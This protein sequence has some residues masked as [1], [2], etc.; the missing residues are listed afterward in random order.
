[1]SA[2]PSGLHKDERRVQIGVRLLPEVVVR[3]DAQ[4]DRL[5]ISRNH[6]IAMLVDYGID[7]L[8]AHPGPLREAT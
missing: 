7:D 5:M 4:A 3:I 8:E 1:M 6:A 2:P